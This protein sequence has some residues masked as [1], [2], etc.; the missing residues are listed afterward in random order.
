MIGKPMRRVFWM[1]IA[2]VFLGTATVA[3][4][5][6]PGCPASEPISYGELGHSGHGSPDD[7]PGTKPDGCLKCCLG[8]CLLGVSLSAPGNVAAAPGFDVAAILYWSGPAVL[9]GRAIKPDPAPPRANA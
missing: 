7:H 1:L 9:R 4:S 3:A 2:V 6:L 5:S 8:A